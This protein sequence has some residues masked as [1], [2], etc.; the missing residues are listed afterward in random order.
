MRR[1]LWLLAIGAFGLFIRSGWS[2]SIPVTVAAGDITVNVSGEWS[3]IQMAGWPLGVEPA[4]PILPRRTFV[5]ALPPD[6]DLA[7]VRVVMGKTASRI[8]PIAQPVRPGA[9]MRPTNGDDVTAYGAATSVVNG[10]D[11][12]VYGQ[13]AYFPT[14][15][16][17]LV[18]T[19]KMRDWALAHVAVDPVLYHPALSHLKT[20]DTIAFRIEYSRQ[21]TKTVATRDGLM[22]QAARALVAN[23]EA[24]SA[25][26]PQPATILAAGAGDGLAILTTEAILNQNTNLFGLISHKRA[27]GFV[28]QVITETKVNGNAA[29]AGWNETTG[30]YPNEKADKIR[31]WLKANYQALRLRYVLL[32]GDPTPD[33]GDLPMK[34]CWPNFASEYYRECPT[35]Y[36]F[37][38]L[39]GN[40]DLDGDGHYGEEGADAGVGGVDFTPEVYVG[41]IPVYPDAGWPATLESIIQKTI[42]YENSTTH[43]WRKKAL[44]PLSYLDPNTDE[45][46]VGEYVKSDILQPAGWSGYT[47]YEQGSCSAT[48]DSSF[49]SNEEL[50]DRATVN[51]WKNNAYGFTFWMGHGW[52]NGAVCCSGNIFTSDHADELN[53]QFPGVVFMGSC[54]CGHPETHNNVSYSVLKNGA[55]AAFGATRVSWYAGTWVPT[56]SH[57][58]IAG[59]G[60]HIFN[61]AVRSNM[62]FA[63]AMYTTMATMQGG[64]AGGWWMNRMD[65]S[66]NG[67]P[68]LSFAS[69]GVD[70]DGDSMDD[71]WETA[72]GFNPNDATDGATDADGDGLSNAQEYGRGSDPRLSD[73]DLDGISDATDG[74]PTTPAYAQMTLT[75]ELTGYLSGSISGSGATWFPNG[76]QWG[77]DRWNRYAGVLRFNLSNLPDA[78]NIKGV[79]LRYAGNGPGWGY[80][81]KLVGLDGIDAV[82]APAAADSAITA[83]AGLQTIGPEF[84]R[85][86]AGRATQILNAN[87]AANLAGRLA[88]DRWNLGLGYVHQGNTSILSLTNVSLVVSYEVPRSFY[89]SMT[90]AG[91]FNGWNQTLKNMKLVGDYLWQWD[92]ALTNASAVRFK[93]V[94]NSDWG[95]NWGEVNQTD[96]I[97]PVDGAAEQGYCGDILVNGTLNGAYRITFNELTSVYR[98]EFVPPPDADG[99]GLPDAWENQ[100]GLNPNDA[101]DAGGNPDGDAYTNLQEF[102]NGTDPR[103]YNAP[104]SGFTSLT[105]AGTFNGWNQALNNLRL[106]SD[107]TWQGTVTVANASAVR[108]KFVANAN[109]S[110]NWGEQNQS[111]FDLPVAGNAERGNYGDITINGTLNGSY[112]VTFHEQTGAYTLALLP[113][114][115][116]DGDGLPDAWEIL[117]GFNPNGSGDAAV[118]FDADGLTNVQEFQKGTHPWRA[119]SDFDG[120]NDAADAQPLAP[121]GPQAVLMPSLQGTL[122]TT[123]EYSSPS[124]TGWGFVTNY[125]GWETH[126][127]NSL[128]ERGYLQFDTT[129]IPDGAVVQS[130]VLRYQAAGANTPS[131]T[132]V[133]LYALD[134]SNPLAGQAENL[135]RQMGT[136]GIFF[137]TNNWA[138]NTGREQSLALPAPFGPDLKSK[139]AANR[140]A[141]GLKGWEGS[142]DSQS[143]YFSNCVLVVNYTQPR[144]SYTSL[145]VAGTF[146]GWNQALNN[147]ALVSDYTWQADLALNNASAVRFKFVA[148]ANWSVNWGEQN[149][150][151]FDLPVAGAAERGN[152]D[153][154]VNG[155]L[156]GTYRFTFNE[157]TGAYTLTLLPPPDAD[158]DGLP[159]AWEIQYSL[160]PNSALDAAQDPDIDGFTN[161]QEY[162][163]GTNPRAWDAMKSDYSTM[164][165]PG[166][167]NN[168]DLQA[169][170]MRLVDNYTWQI[171]F[172]FFSSGTIDLK[173]AAN[174]GWGVNWGDRDQGSTSVPVSG[175][176]E[177]DAA[178]IRLS[179]PFSGYYRLTFNERTGAYRFG[180]KP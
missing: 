43:A 22:D 79:V 141:L 99:D 110:V 1:I 76:L 134:N 161:L 109:W 167:Y 118:D 42:R 166:T 48:Y 9:A 25:W 159:D 122:W 157:Q 12:G 102:Q 78:A 28:V 50:L 158:G 14:A 51:H 49:A 5:Y 93:M 35:D 133:T 142:Y 137:S 152:G 13:D 11:S 177:R 26:Y 18:G 17:R 86:Y 97:L 169:Y 91:T 44:L 83:S 45:G 39:T 121:N 176:V 171:D 117:Y 119:D 139:L 71:A 74:A 61:Y 96:F 57:P 94:A 114:P 138:A 70:T 124:N 63:E 65:F 46:V 73:T 165:V 15:H 62:T 147:L 21:P 31:Q 82:T 143:L 41:R 145:T 128:H 104:R 56:Y 126:Y 58:D 154:T 103:T 7:S 90:V 32:I 175:Y 125:T 153:I 16:A 33:T 4:R 106:T 131:P 27:K 140:W 173:F 47:L 156:N 120:V 85:D 69:G 66:M 172:T 60:Y 40:W 23:A 19:S 59:V 89:Q 87:A 113:P 68:T 151:D 55:I 179:G 123:Y 168:W 77:V 53:N 144:S 163:N 108:F 178:N 3:D 36:Y 112:R 146:N 2:D 130:M 105:I 84:P 98:L 30:Q 162:R 37:A 127:R 10:L 64:A 75:P 150:S 6:V 129:Q 20:T 95:L 54:T 135:Y 72:N 107:Y 88:A 149:Q 67:D 38:D 136:N 101:T 34:M 80:Q 155:T 81:T 170:K 116:A 52:Q 29:A 24:A 180:L 8:Q 132:V 148:N 115:D 92:G 111:D 174:G 100:Y 160:D 164:S